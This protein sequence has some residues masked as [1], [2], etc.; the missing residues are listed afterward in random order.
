LGV[1]LKWPSYGQNDD[2]GRRDHVR[3]HLLFSPETKG[4]ELVSQLTLL[5]A[6]A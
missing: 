2:R 4:K 3:H 5:E 1:D 6:H